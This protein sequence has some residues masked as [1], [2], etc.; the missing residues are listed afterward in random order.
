VVPTL[1]T[2]SHSDGSKLHN[3][4]Q[5]HVLPVHWLFCFSDTTVSWNP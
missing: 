1:V 4:S 3:P 5:Q 2:E